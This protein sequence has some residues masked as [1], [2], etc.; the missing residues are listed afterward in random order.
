MEATVDEVG[1]IV[2]PKLLRDRLRLMPGSK[3]D[4][5][6]YGDGLHITPISRTARVEERD[7]KLV[8]VADTPVTDD[9][10]FALID[11]ARR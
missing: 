10:V 9:D 5:S 11:A 1:R 7:G 3:V 2:V 6:E 8:A 4:V